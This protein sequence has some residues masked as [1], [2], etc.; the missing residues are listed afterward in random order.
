M[1][2]FRAYIT[3]IL[4]CSASLFLI[5]CSSEHTSPTSP[6]TARPRVIATSP[7]AG[8]TQVPTNTS[9]T[10]TFSESIDPNSVV[11]LINGLE[12]GPI[13][14][15][16]SIVTLTLSNSLFQKVEYT[17]A[18]LAGIKDRAGNRMDST[19]TWG[20]TTGFGPLGEK[21]TR[22][23]SPTA[24]RLNN[25]VRGSYEF[26]AVGATGTMLASDDGV[27]W[28]P[29]SFLP[30]ADQLWSAY[31]IGDRY[32]VTGSPGTILASSGLG[33]WTQDTLVDSISNLY[34]IWVA[35]DGIYMVGTGGVSGTDGVVV[36]YVSPTSW[37]TV[38]LGPSRTPR[39]ITQFGGSF[40]IVG[41]SGLVLTSTDGSIWDDHSLGQAWGALERVRWSDQAGKFIAVGA[42][43]ISSANGTDW[44]QHTF[45]SPKLFRD[46]GWTTLTV[47]GITYSLYCAV[48][49]AGTICTS[50]D[51]VNWT[52]QD[53]GVTN[54]LY[55][56][57]RGLVPTRFVVVGEGGVILTSE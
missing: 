57:A 12:R 3:F 8:A 1:A 6:D 19:Y 29:L 10:V 42:A 26:L 52:P 27:A 32:V 28:A 51:A 34:D 5:T 24:T 18:V 33:S 47:G 48:G 44:T 15:T 11:V 54:D 43:I 17:G 30:L 9:V 20:F 55:G 56:I 38:N 14:V 2:P 53:A 31:P 7:A 13:S 4:F 23:T 36:K 45:T 22:Q 41:D 35:F 40:V 46:I 25:V 16:D 37:T 49:D 50:E 39:S 21:W